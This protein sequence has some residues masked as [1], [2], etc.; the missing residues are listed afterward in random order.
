MYLIYYIFINQAKTIPS[1]FT[2][3]PGV[4]P[5][6]AVPQTHPAG[7]NLPVA[8]WPLPGPGERHFLG[9]CAGRICR[10]TWEMMIE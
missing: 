8:G 2:V 3:S 5:A 6:G 9:D 4:P 1:C 7:L 10:K